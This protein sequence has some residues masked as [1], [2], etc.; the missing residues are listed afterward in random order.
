MKRTSIFGGG[1]HFGINTLTQPFLALYAAELGASTGSIGIMLTMKAVIPLFIAMPSGQ[2]IDRLGAAYMLRYGNILT[3]AS[4]AL[5]V[6][7]PTLFFLTLSQLL[8]GAGSMI[9]TSSLQVI[10]SEGE[11]LERERNISSYSAWCSAGTMLGPLIGG[12][13]ITLIATLPINHETNNALLGYRAAFLVA[14]IFSVAFGIMF[15][16]VSRHIPKSA[17]FKGEVKA[18]IQPKE[19]A[20]SYLQGAYLLKHPGVQFGL[21]G[22]FLIHFIQSIWVGFFPLFLDTLG[23]SA[24]LISILVS[25]RGL[26]GMLSR[27]FVGQMIKCWTYQAILITAGC[28]AAIS[29]IALPILDWNIVTIALVS[30]VL[31]SAV[32]INMPVSTMIMVDEDSMEGR[33]KVMGLRLLTNRSSQIA[34]PLIF[35]FFGEFIG[36]TW[37]FYTSGGLLFVSLLGFGLYRKNKVRFRPA[38]IN[39]VEAKS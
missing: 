13:I 19:I 35:G 16:W 5:M 32:G 4:L 36:L 27:L 34:A 39:N 12:G 31:G 8:M 24:M 9:V 7:S 25:I 20:D 6:W 18:V 37:A 10:V 22:T 3:I 2:L 15:Y 17:S 26:A 23:Y 14:L 21:V 11:K 1:L 38:P 29:L 33:G 30:F 28:V